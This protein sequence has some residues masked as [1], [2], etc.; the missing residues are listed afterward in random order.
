MSLVIDASM[1]LS[2]L[3]ERQK[4]EEKLA[5]AKALTTLSDMQGIAP[6]LWHIEI[7][8]ALL[9]GERRG[10]ITQAQTSDFLFKLSH[11]PIKT[12]AH[13]NSPREVI[14]S[15]AREY[16]LSSY[17]AL[18]LDLA[19]NTN[20]VLATFDRNLAKAMVTAGGNVFS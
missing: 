3:F 15:L 13:F 7:I 17:D 12:D 19:L 6:E 20:S 14:L 5:S 4:S 16:Q 8:N 1:A 11:L 10:V 9:V 18:Y 2:W